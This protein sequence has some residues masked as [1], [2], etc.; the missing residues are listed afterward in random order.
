MVSGAARCGR[1]PVTEYNQPNLNLGGTAKYLFF[2][3][4][5]CSKA[6]D[7]HL[8]CSWGDFDY[9]RFHKIGSIGEEILGHFNK[10]GINI[11]E[12]FLNDFHNVLEK[13]KRIRNLKYLEELEK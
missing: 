4:G 2:N 13:K 6:G 1:L 5:A 12:S 8:Q 7:E 10:N 3:G 11:P 9:L